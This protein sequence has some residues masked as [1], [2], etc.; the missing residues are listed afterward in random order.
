MSSFRFLNRIKYQL[1]AAIVDR[2]FSLPESFYR[3]YESADLAERAM[4][5]ANLF[6]K[7]MEILLKNSLTAIF[8]FLYLFRMFHYS[9]RLTWIALIMC[10][11]STAICLG[12]DWLQI[13]YDRERMTTDGR[14][15]S[16]L[17]QLV[18]GV[19][20][21]RISGSEERGIREYTKL[22]TKS[23]ELSIRGS[24]IDR[25]EKTVSSMFS[26]I[27]MIVL[28]YTMIH[29]NM[30][31]S[32]GAFMGFN[33][34]YGSFS[35]AL[36]T[37]VSC[38]LDVNDMIP[39]FGRIKPIL[40]ATPEYS[41]SLAMPGELEGE[42]ELTK[43]KF[44]YRADLPEILHGIDLKIKPGEYIG[45]VGETGGGKSTLLKLLLG[46]ENPTEGQ[47]FYDGMDIAMLD[48]RELRKKFG[49]VLQ[50]GGLITGSIRENITITNPNATEEE[51]NE[52]VANAG[53]TDDIKKMP[54]GL[55]TVMSEGDGSVSGGQK[56]RILI[57]RAIVGKP[58]ILFFDEAT[59]ALD[60]NT[61]RIV[62]EG[63]DSLHSTRVVIAH[64]L[65]TIINCDRIIVLHN[66]V[67]EECGNFDELM[68]NKGYFY[69]LASRQMA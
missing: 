42:I 13:K 51:I 39:A 47:I 35:G 55:N 27:I 52:A 64:R 44:S 38:F 9:K 34:A 29:K 36:G 19:G 16:L 15:S 67:I 25:I 14:I 5:I 1:E 2:L 61:Q 11:L 30:G 28:Y 66:G 26:T 21:L 31:L 12:L 7:L 48:K 62:R 24:K 43:V 33:S 45:V 63:L 56:Q 68:A 54:M 49:V 6:T 50:D 58:K 4:T 59:S 32:I 17:Y 60:N 37:L 8:S 65:S 46:F 57:A 20:K 40:Q 69:Q 41:S 3:D 22:Y 53:L 10:L 18:S 23:T